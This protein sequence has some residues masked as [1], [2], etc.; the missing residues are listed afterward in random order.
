MITVSIPG[1]SD[2]ELHHL[3]L[4]MNGTLATDGLVPDGVGELIEQLKSQLNVYLLTADTFG[5]GAAAA[6]EL[7][8]ELITVSSDNGT[9]DK[10]NFTNSL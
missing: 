10:A 8:I 3:I 6:R 2:L 5:T 9:I 4:D 1:G 7:G